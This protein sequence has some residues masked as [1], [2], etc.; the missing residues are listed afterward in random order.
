MKRRVYERLLYIC[1]SQNW[2][3][4][5]SHFWIKQCIEVNT[6]ELLK[7]FSLNCLVT[8]NKFCIFRHLKLSKLLRHL[9]VYH[10]SLVF[11]LLLAVCE[12]NTIIGTSCQGSMLPSITNVINL[13]D[14]H[15]RA[16]FAMATHV[17]QEPRERENSETKE[18]VGITDALLPMCYS[19]IFLLEE[20]KQ[21]SLFDSNKC[22]CY[23][24][25][26]MKKPKKLTNLHID[27][28]FILFYIFLFYVGSGD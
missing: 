19:Y 7:P 17:K 6:A 5:G 13:A 25:L 18:E 4:M 2:E 21:S 8:L 11:Q 12:R 10:F 27:K 9:P 1:C 23:Q 20:W 26:L 24:H 28:V 3:A 14:S 22:A 15:D 16:A